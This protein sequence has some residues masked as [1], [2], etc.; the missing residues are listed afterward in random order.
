L[1]LLQ[2]E[3]RV[4]ELEVLRDMAFEKARQELRKEILPVE[5]VPAIAESMSGI[6][7]G[8]NLSYIGIEKQ[9]L[10]SILPIFDNFARMITQKITHD[11]GVEE[12]K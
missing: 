5:Q 12:T 2:V 10:T 4:R 6:F 3:N 8:A 7:Q 9:L 11:G 1:E